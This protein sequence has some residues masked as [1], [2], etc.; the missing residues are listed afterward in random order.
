MKKHICFIMF[1]AL[2]QICV[3]GQT[4][5]KHLMEGDNAYTNNDYIAAEENYRKAKE[6]ESSLKSN[7]NLGNATYKQERFEEAI[8]YYLNATNKAKNVSEKSSA[9]YNLGNSYFQNQ[10]FEKAVD[11]YKRSIK[12]DPKNK[13]ARYNLSYTKEILKQLAQ[14]QQQQQ[15]QDQQNQDQ[16]D[17]QEKSE[18]DQQNQEQN[19]GENQDNT[20]KEEQE[21]QEQKEQPQ[22]S[23]QQS[24]PMSFDSSRLDKQSLD[25]LDAQK[26]LQII[27]DEEMKVQEKLRKFNS[28]RK[29]PD[30]DW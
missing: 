6:K 12:A 10:E 18:Q 9:F 27:Q 13:D 25:S 20:E 30:K 29:K 16:N 5:H 17:Q 21:E 4:A 19:Q 24:Q 11:A 14:Q 15:N 3:F 2:N 28:K 7:F 23:T 26:L 1:F 22:D 8:D